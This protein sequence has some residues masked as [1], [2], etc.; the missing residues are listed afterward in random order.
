V[1]L[2]GSV[3]GEEL[4]VALKTNFP[5]LLR[6]FIIMNRNAVLHRIL[7]GNAAIFPIDAGQFC[8]ASYWLTASSHPANRN[9]CPE[10]ISLI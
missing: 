6:L 3:S 2:D 1:L 5:L 8:L 4:M 7:M 10:G 9:I